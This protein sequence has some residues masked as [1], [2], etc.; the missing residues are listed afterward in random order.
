MRILYHCRDVEAPSGGV[1]RLY[2]HV[3]VLS[4]NGYQAAILH[5]ARGFR[6]AWFESSAPITYWDREAYLSEEDILVIPE[7][8]IDVLASTAL[9]PC[10][11]L[12]IALNWANIFRHLP[13]GLDWRHFGLSGIIAGSDYESEFIKRTM[14]LASTTIPS[15]TDSS[16]FYPMADKRRQ[17]AYMP[18]KNADVFRLIEG[19]FR[20]GFPEYRDVPF[21]PIDGAGHEAVAKILRE[22][23]WFLATS[24]PEG[25]ARPPLEAM[26]S[27]CIVVGF[28]GRGSLE[29]MHHMENCYLADDM[30]ILAAVEHL[31]AAIRARDGGDT[32]GMQQKARQTALAYSLEREEV[33]ILTFWRN[34]IAG[35]A[36]N[37]TA[38][39]VTDD[40]IAYTDIPN[41]FSF[42]DVYD[43]LVAEGPAEGVFVEVGTWLGCSVAY[44]ASRIKASGKAL[45]LCA[46]DNF[47]GQGS[48]DLIRAEVLQLGGSFFDLFC[49]N[50][51]RCG[52][53]D[54]VTP[55]LS[56]SWDAAKRFPDHS[57]AA[58]FIDA[59][60]TYA[61]VKRD[62][63][64]W[65]PKIAD[66]GVIAGHDYDAAHPGVIRA[67]T[68]VFS[69]PI[70]EVM[71]HSWFVRL[72]SSG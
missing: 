7:G 58:V 25:L 60:H 21:I 61:N 50:I 43:R 65:L 35:E 37:A 46:V 26:A 14:G 69:G 38:K 34:F 56:E 11:R 71:R 62:I 41:H 20:A 1:R 15:G 53:A 66:G 29:Y 2:R 18:R 17:I 24:F 13:I 44:L 72:P 51:R 3:E 64:A 28:A 55:V 63:L 30:D 42:S 16:L 45:A 32:A 47:T 40:T 68:E 31:G 5:R 19:A 6:P 23:A 36:C 12:V 8:H 27:G 59:S 39:E 33:N 52:I 54:Y 9:L 4:K 70:I 48:S 67:V 22:S 49:Q 57:V 10:R